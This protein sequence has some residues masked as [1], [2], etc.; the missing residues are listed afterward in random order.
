[1]NKIHDKCEECGNKFKI[2]DF[3]WKCETCEKYLDSKCVTNH[4]N[5]ELVPLEY[6]SFNEFKLLPVVAYGGG[7][8]GTGWTLYNKDEFLENINPCKHALKKLKTHQPVFK[9]HENKLKCSKC[10]LK[11]NYG[12]KCNY[13]P[14]VLLKNNKIR[15]L[16]Y[17][18][19]QSHD[20]KLTINGLKSSKLGQNIEI[21][22][23]IENLKPNF[24][25]N[26]NLNMIPISES[27]LHRRDNDRKL[28]LSNHDFNKFFSNKNKEFS[29]ISPK[30][31]ENLIFNFDIPSND[32][33][34]NFHSLY[35]SKIIKGSNFN[36]RYTEFQN[37]L[38]IL[39]L[40]SYSTDIGVVYSYCS[41]YI[42]KIDKNNDTVEIKKCNDGNFCKDGNLKVMI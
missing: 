36:N 30:S 20:V 37:P 27:N 11:E 5:H 35:N 39:F 18:F 2:G 17:D 29:M 40:F 10:Y 14:F 26:V 38:S 23:K 34:L 13:E 41:E 19:Y 12:D 31:S 25:K 9:N 4:L 42:L 16:H 21:D 15:L 32:E 24:I 8:G 22:I 33:I 6:I 7:L 1:M 3:I 28:W